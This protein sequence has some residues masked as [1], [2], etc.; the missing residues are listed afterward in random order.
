MVVWHPFLIQGKSVVQYLATNGAYG[1]IS[2]T[3]QLECDQ[4]EVELLSLKWFSLL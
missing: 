3:N 1:S 4:N 2:V